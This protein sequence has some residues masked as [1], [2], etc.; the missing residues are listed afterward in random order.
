[1]HSDALP[2]EGSPKAMP[3]PRDNFWVGSLFDAWAD[4]LSL[5]TRASREHGDLVQFRFAWMRYYLIN[6]A[7]AAHHVLIENAKG[8]HKSPNYQGL[9][10]ILGQGLLT[11]EGD[12]WRRQRKL[13][14]PAFHR[15]HLKGFASTMVA[16]TRNTVTRWETEVAGKGSFDIHAEMMRLTFRIV[17]QTLLGA[18][19]ESDAKD[20]GAALNVGLKWANEYVESVV[21]VPPWVPT[22]NNVRFR[23]AQRTIEGVVGKV[24]ADRKASSE[25]KR[26]LLGMLMSARDEATGEAMSDK[27]LMEELL[28]LTLAGHE[29]TANA[30]AFTFYLLSSH[31][32]IARRAN[33][34]VER[35]LGGREPQLED[36]AKMPF[37]KAIIEEALRLYPPAW[38]VERVA[39]EEDVVNGYRI[40]KG[41]I[42]GVSAYMMHRNPRY[43]ENPEGFDP[44]RWLK[45]DAARPKLAYMPFGGG[46]RTC[47]GNAFAMMELQIIV[48][49]LLQR[50]QL[51]LS[52][53]FKLE[54]DPSVTLRPKSGIW[55][56][57]KR[58][59]RPS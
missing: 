50:F 53:G 26:D 12:L 13:A 3:G 45:P 42:V 52:P 37:V 36:L 18:D 15:E 1:M 28:T 59:S 16:A 23:R 30:L 58:A 56:D 51:S 34:E 19:L 39:L 31:P 9:K 38:V 40:P 11:S 8:Y 24:V 7:A 22:P 20:F 14:Q 17:G 25:E 27:L 35:A 10:V 21:R 5:F 4:P 48:P 32:D 54:L 57:A 46:P 55:M 49:M 33:D 44:D 2:I 29:T 47:I 41:G 43:F 6:D